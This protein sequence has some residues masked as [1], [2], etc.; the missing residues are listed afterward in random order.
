MQ[1]NGK[2]KHHVLVCAKDRPWNVPGGACHQR[3]GQK[4]YDNLVDLVAKAKLSDKIMITPMSCVG[5]CNLGPI[6]IIYP[7]N[8]WY[9]KV[10]PYHGVNKIFEEH[11]LGGNVVVDMLLPDYVWSD[12]AGMACER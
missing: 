5:L 9:M 2:L 8:I 3:E 6:V 1:G 7:D 4:V 10:C 12:L 11:L